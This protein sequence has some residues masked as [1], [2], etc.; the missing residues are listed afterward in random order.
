MTLYHEID[1][2]DLVKKADYNATIDD[3]EKN[4]NRGILIIR[5]HTHTHT[6]TRTHTHTHT[7]TPI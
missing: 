3:I 4:C 1:T 2:S 5:T 6:Y 7:H